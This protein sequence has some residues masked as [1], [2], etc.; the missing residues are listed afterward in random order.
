MNN[1]NNRPPACL[2]IAK[3]TI[4]RE[5][6]SRENIDSHA[7]RAYQ[8]AISLPDPVEGLIF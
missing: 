1:G 8:P 6:F 3:I 2:R 5:L 4:N 7:I